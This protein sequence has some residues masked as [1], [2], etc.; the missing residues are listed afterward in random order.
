[1]YR[2][3][4]CAV[5]GE[6]LPPDHFYCREHAAYVDD[7]L[8]EIGAVLARL[9]DDLPRL[10]ALLGAVAPETWDYLA[11]RQGAADEPEWPP[12]VTLTLRTGA[13][14][15]DVDVDRE[16]G[17]VRVAVS[18]GL[19]AMVEALGQALAQGGVSEL[20]AA[21]RTADGANATH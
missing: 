19:Q 10:S 15:V 12:A 2:D 5:C 1:M 7:R 11:E 3:D 14:D 9:E 4:V 8:R 13:D 20:A 17:Q 21:C 18:A 16:P 6:S